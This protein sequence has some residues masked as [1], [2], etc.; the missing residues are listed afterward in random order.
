VG[1]GCPGPGP[2]C[3][4]IDVELPDPPNGDA[5]G[6]DD[7]PVVVDAK[8]LSATVVEL[9]FSKSLAPVNDVEPLWFR[10]SLA[11]TRSSYYSCDPQTV[12]Q[13]LGSTSQALVTSVWNVP[14]DL[15]LLRLSLSTPVTPAHCNTIDN[16]KANGNE[17]GLFVHYAAGDGAS[18]QD[19]DGN[20]LADIAAPWVRFDPGS[21]GYYG[22]GG[23][24]GYEPPE[25]T[26]CTGTACTAEMA[27]PNMDSY[28][29]IPCVRE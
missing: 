21:Y 14:D 13:D 12:Y 22:Y 8:M 2:D 11:T 25:F 16:A 17:A 10:I 9:R 28:L 19:L 4:P 1:A 29:P 6:A 20:A 18:V 3:G 26:F 5:V 7:A 27:F 23:Y 24:G 15:E